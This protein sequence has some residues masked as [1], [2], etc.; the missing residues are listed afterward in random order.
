MNI[1]REEYMAHADIEFSS[2]VQLD[3]SRVSLADEWD[4]ELNTRRE[5]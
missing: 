3:S 1:H 2:S 4:A 5:N